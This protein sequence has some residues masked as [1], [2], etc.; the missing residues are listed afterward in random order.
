MSIPRIAVTMGDPAGIG[1]EV[2]AKTLTAPVARDLGNLFVVGSAALLQDWLER[3]ESE[4]TIRRIES[5]P[6]A[7]NRDGVVP[8]LDVDG[9]AD[10]T[11]PIAELSVDAARAAHAWV[12]RAA[13][14]CL[15]G[16][17]DA[18]VTAPVNKDAFS[19]ADIADTGHQEIL[20]R[21]SG[22]PYVATMLV[23]GQLRCMHLSTHKPLR[24][25]CAFVTRANVLRAIELTHEHFQR[26]GYPE[27]RIAV[28]AL[29][30]H[31]S[32]NGLI[33]HEELEEIGPAVE[34][35][36]ARGIDATGPHPADSV[37][38]QAIDGRYDVVV[39]MYHDQGHIAI[40]VHGFEQSVTVNLGLPFIR[41]SVDHGTAFDIAGKGIA[42]CTSMVEAIRLASSLATGARLS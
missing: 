37:F 6:E 18:M 29:N 25:A 10:T 36:R 33:G 8:I 21:L 5:A 24:D 16:S 42:D 14:M 35:A 22:S 34:D 3:L 32:D 23:S 2:V 4:H 41:T 27:P 26:W 17:I 28:A 38:T 15:D 20:Q 11:F 7:D 40:K 1:P 9:F 31:A 39:V 13:R 19:K 30:P 12:E